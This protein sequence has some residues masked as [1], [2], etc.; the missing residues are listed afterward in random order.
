MSDDDSQI[1]ITFSKKVDRD[2]RMVVPKEHRKALQ[3]DGR[4]ALVEFQA[5]TVTYLD[6]G[7]EGSE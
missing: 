7:G 5:K 2:G 3:I 4:E 6:E 1:E